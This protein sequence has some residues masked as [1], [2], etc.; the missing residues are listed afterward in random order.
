MDTT[1]KESAITPKLGQIRPIEVFSHK[2]RQIDEKTVT[3]L[4]KAL[5]RD[6]SFFHPILARDEGASGYRLISGHHRLET[7]KRCFGEQAAIC[8]SIL[9]PNTPD[10][11]T[12]ILEIEE[13][14]F[15]KE[16]TAAERQA[17]T[18]RL[19]AALKKLNGWTPPVSVSDPG[20]AAESEKRIPT[21]RTRR[22]RGNKGMAQRVADKLGI[23]KRT[24]NMRRK[25]AAAAIGEKIDLDL[26]TPEEL[27]RKADKCLRAERKIE[28]P[29][30]RR[31]A[32]RGAMDLLRPFVK[33]QAGDIGGGIEGALKVL[34]AMSRAERLLIVY[35]TCIGL[36]L[37]P[38]KMAPLEAFGLADEKPGVAQ[39]QA[40]EVGS[41]ID[42]AQGGEGGVR[43]SAPRTCGMPATPPRMPP[44]LP[45][46]LTTILPRIPTI[47]LSTTTSFPQLPTTSL[48]PKTTTFS[49]TPARRILVPRTC[50]SPMMTPPRMP[51][52]IR[53]CHR[54]WFRACRRRCCR[55]CR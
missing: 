44:T 32:P 17:E 52:M 20:E 5:A 26:D 55:G 54:Q 46:I 15:R 50:R 16:L 2:R 22:G 8:A 43:R 35:H 29:E 11:L 6:G 4:E 33:P 25:S 49:S 48:P 24:V 36:G 19:A 14:L 13:N 23:G 40:A 3:D 28:R 41:A 51:A 21:S 30:R 53:A 42:H 1:F 45:T 18:I 37:D 31:P 34:N 27:E 7:W 47:T 38:L 39:D 10:A 9:P 12:V